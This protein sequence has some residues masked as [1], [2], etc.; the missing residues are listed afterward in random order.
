[1]GKLNNAFYVQNLRGSTAEVSSVLAARMTG[2]AEAMVGLAHGM[3]AILGY[4]PDLSQAEYARIARSL[5]A[6]HDDIRNIAAAPNLV[7]QY[8]HPLGPNRDVLGLDYRENPTQLT[9]VERVRLTGKTVFAGP[10]DFVQGGRGFIVRA[11][12]FTDAGGRPKPRFWGIVSVAIDEREFF[13]ANGLFEEGLKIDIALR[14]VDGLGAAGATFF[15]SPELFKQNPVITRIELPSGYWELAA[16]PKGGWPRFAKNAPVLRAIYICAVLMIL[17]AAWYFIVLLKRRHVAE[18]RLVGAI[19]ALNDGFALFDANDRLVISNTKYREFYSASANIIKPGVTF[20]EI[21]REGLRKGQ[22]E[23]AIGREEE[24]IQARLAS[25]RAA[26]TM[27]EQKLSDGRWLRI[28]ERRSADGSTVGFRVDITELK[29]AKEAAEAANR[30]KSDFLNILSHE[31]RTPLTVILGSAR[32]LAQPDSL[33]AVKALRAAVADKGTDINATGAKVEAVLSTLSRLA[34]KID[35]T[36]MHLL[37]L[38]NEML[39]FSKIE[40]GKMVLDLEDVEV[41]PLLANLGMEF[42]SIA[43]QKGLT[44]NWECKDM[45]VRAD[46]LRLKQTLINL[47]SNAIKFTDAGTITIR[48]VRKDHAVEFSVEDTGCGIA[49][50]NLEIVF[51]QFEQADTSSTRRAKGTGLG[52]AIVKRIVELHGGQIALSSVVGQGSVFR[53]TISAGPNHPA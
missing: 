15:G 3:V 28:A 53:F 9:T 41:K 52:L 11:P 43:S 23:Q 38:I 35:T 50:E 37:V 21:V 14:G 2:H 33:P 10:V 13:Q 34:R 5:M 51:R 4:K 17:A 1:M 27:Q 42:G 24:W 22:Y 36:G 39:D 30:A 40:A 44:L 31:L 29:Q 48:A 49:P 12:V 47:V 32:I 20:E 8:V 25:H 16:V 45:V 26:D 7:V 46:R 18:Q 19:E 6:G